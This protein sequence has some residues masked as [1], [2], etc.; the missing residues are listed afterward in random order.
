MSQNN[1]TVKEWATLLYEA[2]SRGE[3]RPVCSERIAG[4]DIDLAYEAQGEFAK[5][6]MGLGSI[7]GFK[8]AL[9]SKAA[10]DAM[11]MSDP[12]SGVMFD[13]MQVP[14]GSNVELSRYRRIV[15]ETEIGYCIGKEI[16]A[17][18]QASELGDFIEYNFPMVEIAD[19]GFDDPRAMTPFDF[20]AAGSAAAG[21]IVGQRS[22][23]TDVN[24][25]EVS[26]SCDGELLHTGKGSDA[27]G[28]QTKAA[29][30]LINHAVSLGYTLMPGHVLMTGSLGRIRMVT[31]AGEYLADFGNF[32]AIKFLV[33]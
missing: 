32:G 17:P 25:V 27:M 10:Q 15:I 30:W 12:A 5:L 13:F 7:S 11:G 24:A 6:R 14:L 19:I 22:S 3:A 4:V 18:I 21:Y 8:G 26:L 16:S 33:V 31:E 1:L 28:D 29:T 20:V 23:D 2:S 9:T